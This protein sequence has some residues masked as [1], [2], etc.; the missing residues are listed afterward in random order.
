MRRSANP[1]QVLRIRFIIDR[2]IVVITRES[3][4]SSNQ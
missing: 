3:G 4:R 2:L 1:A